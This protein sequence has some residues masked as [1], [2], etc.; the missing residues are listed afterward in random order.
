MIARYELNYV[1]RFTVFLSSPGDVREERRQALELLSSFARKRRYIDRATVS[2][3]SWDDPEEPSPA[4][5]NEAPQS[6][7]NDYKRRPSDCDLT[8]AIVWSRLGTPLSKETFAR[9]DGTGFSSGTVWEIEDALSANRPV[10]VFFSQKPLPRKRTAEEKMQTDRL[11]AY[12][13]GLLG[14]Q[15]GAAAGR[16]QEFDGPGQFV[17]LLEKGKR[18]SDRVV[19]AAE[20]SG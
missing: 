16:I 6:V 1:R 14:G 18:S 3:V 10:L 2:V 7:I 17:R 19:P 11:D 5:L 15:S 9:A 12:L 4:L 8:V 13:E 20:Q